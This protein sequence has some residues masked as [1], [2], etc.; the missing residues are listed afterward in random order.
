V[1]GNPGVS[2]RAICSALCLPV[3]LAEYH[4]GVLIRSGLISFVRDG[5]Y[6][7]FFVAKRFSKREML[8]ICLLRHKTP[9]RIM[10][11]LLCKKELAHGKLA[12]DVSISSQ[13]LTWH[14]KT[15]ANTEFIVQ[16][17]DG[18]KTIYRLDESPEPQ[19]RT[20]LPLA[21]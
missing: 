18:L 15:L 10:E 1:N 13:A 21:S 11:I 12:V 4:L 17:N 16:F 6:K 9:K 3:G 8:A 7:R 19:L 2:F 5:R 14:M 20:Y